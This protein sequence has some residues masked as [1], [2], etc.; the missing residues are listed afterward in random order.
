MLLLLLAC[1]ENKIS[2]GE[3][4]PVAAPSAADFGEVNVGTR[5][6]LGLRL[7]ND[8]LGFYSVLDAQ[9]EATSADFAVVDYS[10]E[11]IGAAD[12]GVLTLSYTPD[13]EGQDYGSVILTTDLEDDASTAENESL[14]ELSLSGFG[15][16]PRLEI[17]PEL[18]YFPDVAA[19]TTATQAFTLSSR[20]SG[21][22]LLKHIVLDDADGVFAWTAPE[23]Y[24]GEPY[25]LQNGFSITME[26]SFSPQ[27]LL[28]HN[29]TI[30]IESNDREDPIASIRLVGNAVDN[31]NENVCP[32]VQILNP[33]NGMFLLNTEVVALTGHVVDP[34]DSL[35][36]LD[37]SWFANG[38]RLTPGVV[39][40]DGL[41]TGSASLPVGDV[42]VSLRC[43]DLEVCAGQDSTEVFVQDAEEP[44]RYTITGGNSIFDY[45]SVDDDLTIYLNGT[46][47]Y[48]DSDRTSSTLAPVEFEARVGDQLRLVATDVNACQMAMDALVLHWGTGFSQPLNDAEC[49]SSCP[50][51]AC[52]DAAYAGPWPSVYLDE[53]YTIAIP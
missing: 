51:D 1:S 35:Q 49:R 19:G 40:T 15:V 3:A 30:Q 9:I 11:P 23:E 25:T 21:K 22:L 47:I 10:K 12:E 37:C 16:I 6:E 52:Y 20:G 45:F 36:D 4:R 46:P 31:P 48:E 8:G 24:T 2:S 7:E 29:A 28:E 18:L 27:D 17:E 5:L 32:V 14:L 43:I 41:V 50:Q 39:D 34:D 44:L 42:E 53:S 13:Y 38:R 26:A 33:D